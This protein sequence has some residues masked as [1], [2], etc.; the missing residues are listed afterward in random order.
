[1]EKLGCFYS[2]CFKLNLINNSLIFILI[3]MGGGM[4]DIDILMYN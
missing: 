4:G 1:M 2:V 3:Y